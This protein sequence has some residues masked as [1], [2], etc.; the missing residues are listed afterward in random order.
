MVLGGRKDPYLGFN[1]LVEI[2]GLVVGGFTEVSGLQAEVE[3]EDYREGGMNWYTHK[4]PGPVRYPSN[5][6]LKQGLTDAALLYG[7]YTQVRMGV[8]V[9]QHISVV[10]LDNLQDEKKR[11]NFLLAYPIK[12][13]GPQLRSNANEVAVETV[14]FV[15][16]GL[17]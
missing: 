1:F 10:L 4:L 15:H 9:R 2:S 3:V 5:L 13:E 7:W 12:W 6:I 8:I 16:K 11:W 17:I 14:E